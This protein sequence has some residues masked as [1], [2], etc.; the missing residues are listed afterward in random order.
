MRLVQKKS[1]FYLFIN[2]NTVTFK[3]RL[4]CL[5][6]TFRVDLPLFVTFLEHRF[7]DVFS[8]LRYSP[9]DVKR[10]KKPTRCNNQMFI[11]N[12]C[13]NMFRASLCPFSGEQSSCVTAYGVLRW[14]CWMWSQ[15]DDSNSSLLGFNGTVLGKCFPVFSK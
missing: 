6:T 2:Y 13:L 1:L 10:E 15:I 4:L 8:G 7:W 14:F 12:F 5:Q 9:L 11:I 3:V